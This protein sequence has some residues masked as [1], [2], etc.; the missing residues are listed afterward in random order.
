MEPFLF[1]ICLMYPPHMKTLQE[2]I[3]TPHQKLLSEGGQCLFGNIYHAYMQ[4]LSAV[5]L[6]SFLY[7]VDF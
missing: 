4:E 5:V 7:Q 6:Y 2:A 1:K 3:H